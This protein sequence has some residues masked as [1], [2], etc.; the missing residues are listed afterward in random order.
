MDPSCLPSQHKADEPAFDEGGWTSGPRTLATRLVGGPVGPFFFGG[1]SCQ[2]FE[3]KVE[4]PAWFAGTPPREG[5]CF[6]EWRATRFVFGRY[7]E[8]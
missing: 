5:D 1:G 6:L 7:Q 2:G 3:Q 8:A 4:Q